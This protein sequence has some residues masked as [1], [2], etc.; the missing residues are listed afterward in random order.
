MR[1]PRSIRPHG[2]GFQA[3]HSGHDCCQ[4]R[5]QSRQSS[6]GGLVRP[7][8][9]SHT[10]P[11]NSAAIVEVCLDAGSPPPPMTSPSSTMATGPAFSFGDPAFVE[12][13]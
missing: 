13:G 10:N 3:G 1:G 7:G 12:K 2:S 4:F 6:S 11:G 9:Y 5:C 8:L